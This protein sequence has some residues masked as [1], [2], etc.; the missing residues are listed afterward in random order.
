MEALQ[1]AA[2]AC[3]WCGSAITNEK[4]EEIQD[5]IRADERRLREAERA[6]MELEH[7]A[8][9]AKAVA[10]AKAQLS[11]QL[12]QQAEVRQ[13]EALEGLRGLLEG[14]RDAA[15]IELANTRTEAA[16]AQAQMA[17]ERARLDARLRQIE[18]ERT[19]WRESEKQRIET[20]VRSEV[21]EDR[22]RLMQERDA[23]KGELTTEKVRLERERD[24]EATRRSMLEEKFKA[25]LAA[26]DEA[27]AKQREVLDA[28]KDRALSAKDSQV[29]KE[30]ETW[31]SQVADLN[32]KLEQKTA[33]ELGEGGE[34]DLYEAL[35]EAFPKDKIR[36]VK[37]GEPGGDIIH[38]VMYRGNVCGRV[39]YDSKNHKQWRNTFV[40]KLRAD[41]T[42]EGADYAI[43]S[44]LKFPEGKRN[45]AVVSGVV[46]AG[47][48]HVVD[49]VVLLRESLIKFHRQGLS[50]EERAG[51][52][53]ALYK[54]IAS[55]PFRQQLEELDRL[56]DKLQEIDVE[57]SRRH[58]KTWEHRGALM[59][60]QKRVVAEVTV[61]V[62]AILG[63]EGSHGRS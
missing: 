13:K 2:E 12:G 44:T 58:N 21:A 54:H 18:A 5:R 9:T 56:N 62:E 15:R 59:K 34:V 49:V 20:A 7:Q 51:K 28:E 60:R 26:R 17:E 38:E 57:E 27:L 35:R 50:L 52:Q 8:H 45:V 63:G 11:A 33:H 1:L 4:F 31:R 43:L 40:E 55:G 29:A 36:R 32:R 6:E 16:S 37:K 3:P 19:E 46:V 25:E 48:K 47:P 41:Q 42:E 23:A 24:A 53:E 22:S 39:L 14:E 61:G 30:R 10:Q